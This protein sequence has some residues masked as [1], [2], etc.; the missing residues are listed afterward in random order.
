MVSVGGGNTSGGDL[1]D[2]GICLSAQSSSRDS[3]AIP[4][5]FRGTE[6]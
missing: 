5:V 2:Y 4:S 6:R 3:M 1:A